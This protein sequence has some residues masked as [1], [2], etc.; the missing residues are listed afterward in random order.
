MEK[1]MKIPKLRPEMQN[2]VLC[3]WL[4]N[5]GDEVK[6]GEP[7]YEIE[8]DKVVNQIEATDSGVLKKQLCEEGDTVD[9]LSPVAILETK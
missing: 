6:A 9:V 4:K 3:A 1:T 8:T 7:V 5:E 2:G